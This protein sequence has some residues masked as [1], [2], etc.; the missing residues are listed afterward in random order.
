MTAF[1][2]AWGVVKSEP[3]A[4]CPNCG[5]VYSESEMDE[6]DA[7]AEEQGIATKCVCGNHAG[8][9]TGRMND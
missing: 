2:K 8:N 7:N 9:F 4:K 5:E 6:M 3:F 1:N